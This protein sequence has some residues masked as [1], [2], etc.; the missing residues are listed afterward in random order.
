MSF[1]APEPMYEIF[2]LTVGTVAAFPDVSLEAPESQFGYLVAMLEAEDA[3]NPSPYS[4]T[5]PF[6]EPGDPAFDIDQSYVDD[7]YLPVADLEAAADADLLSIVSDA[8]PPIYGPPDWYNDDQYH[9]LGVPPGVLNLG[10]PI[11]YGASQMRGNGGSPGPNP[12]AEHG[13]DAWS[14]RTPLAR[15][16]RHENNFPDYGKGVRRRMGDAPVEKFVMPYYLQ[17]QQYRDLLLAELKRR[18]VHEAVVMDVPSVPFTEQVQMIDP[19]A[20]YVEPL[21]GPEGVLP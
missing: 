7:Y 11:E 16:A 19:T 4:R 21:I 2:P 3:N 13:W 17:T 5:P 6:G 12:A 15:V 10:Q 9:G 1:T 8:D 20:Q 14:G 18:G